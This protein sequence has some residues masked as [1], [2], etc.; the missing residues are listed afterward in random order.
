MHFVKC[1]RSTEALSCGSSWSRS[2]VFV[3]ML[4]RRGVVMLGAD[5]RH[6]YGKHLIQLHYSAQV[7]GTGCRG[8]GFSFPS[9]YQ[10]YYQPSVTN[11]FTQD[12]KTN[13]KKKLNNVQEALERTGARL[14][15]GCLATDYFLQETEVITWRRLRPFGAFFLEVIEKPA[16][17]AKRNV[18]SCSS[19]ADAEVSI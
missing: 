14:L 9:R 7:E 8:G 18:P 19:P 15:N 17:G 5:F 16:A 1:C 4:R 12:S 6:F 3:L 2:C 13:K 11:I 10:S